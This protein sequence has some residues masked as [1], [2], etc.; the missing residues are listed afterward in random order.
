MKNSELKDYM[1]DNRDAIAKASR[2][3]VGLII[4]AVIVI[5]VVFYGIAPKTKKK[6]DNSSSLPQ[7]AVTDAEVTTSDEDVQ[8]TAPVLEA[9]QKEE[10]PAGYLYRVTGDTPVL[11]KDG[12]YIGGAGEGELFSSYDE[13]ALEDYGTDKKI[14]ITYLSQEAYIGVDDLAE[15]TQA[16]I[17]PTAGDRFIRDEYNGTVSVADTDSGAVAAAALV[18][19]EKSRKWDKAELI[20][21]R[22]VM[23]CGSDLV[24]LINSYSG[25]DLIAENISGDTVS[26]LKNNIDEGKRV[27]ISVRY[28]NGVVDYDYSDYLGRTSGTQYIVVCGYADDDTDGMC[29]YCC[30]PFYGQG[31]R[32]LCAVSASA[33]DSSYA[34]V[35]PGSKAMI[36]LR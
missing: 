24:K 13:L 19:S 31:G 20:S 21:A 11:D 22:D 27:L 34:L 18:N 14:G 30:D 26:T 29:F 6:T 4:G 23:N 5:G 16:I 25:G 33:I 17:L 7:K 36:T 2:L 3:G 35:E 10:Q 28:D 1:N 15:V 9:M 32:S 8:N 12:N